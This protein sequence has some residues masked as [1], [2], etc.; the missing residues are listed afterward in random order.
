MNLNLKNTDNN[1]NVFLII[2]FFLLFFITIRYC[3]LFSNSL[4]NFSDLSLQY[5]FL[6][7]EKK[8]KKIDN[9]ISVYNYFFAILV[10]LLMII[11]GLVFFIIEKINNNN[12]NNENGNV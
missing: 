7:K 1:N 6:D 8:I 10:V 11:I 5:N 4:Q 3:K 2:V 9:N 12:R